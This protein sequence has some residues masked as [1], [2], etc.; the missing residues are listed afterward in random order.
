MNGNKPSSNR[1]YWKRVE[2]TMLFNRNLFKVFYIYTPFIFTLMVNFKSV[3]YWS[4]C[5]FVRNPVRA[6]VFSIYGNSTITTCHQSSGPNYTSITVCGS[7][8]KK[9]FLDCPKTPS[10]FSGVRQLWIFPS[11][12]MTGAQSLFYSHRPASVNFA[13]HWRIS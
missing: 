13:I 8:H 10:L 4:M 12:V 9:P 11:F 7:P 3:L 1:I 5:K 6:L 2:L